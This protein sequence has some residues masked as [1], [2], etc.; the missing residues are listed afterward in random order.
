[1]VKFGAHSFLW[2]DQWTTEKGNICHQCRGDMGFDYV[3]LPFFGLTSLKEKFIKKCCATRDRSSRIIGTARRIAYARKPEGAKNFSS[4]LYRN[5]R[6]RGGTYL[7]GCIA[8]PLANS[9]VNRQLM[10]NVKLSWIRS[11]S[12]SQS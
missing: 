10:Q 9:P 6:M 5:C 3:E 11:E 8:I 7:C 2:I 1:M 12:S 4:R